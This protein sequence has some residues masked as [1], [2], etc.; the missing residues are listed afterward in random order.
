MC[1]IIKHYSFSEFVATVGGYSFSYLQ[2]TVAFILVSYVYRFVEIA[3]HQ[4]VNLQKAQTFVS[5]V[6]HQ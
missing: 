3:Y 5:T 2:H 1:Y 6:G 4:S